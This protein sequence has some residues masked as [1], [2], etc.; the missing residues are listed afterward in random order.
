MYNKLSK[1]KFDDMPLISVLMAVRN[2]E[3]TVQRAIKSILDQSYPKFEYIIVDDGSNDKTWGILSTLNDPRILLLRN[4]ESR[5]LAYCLNLAFSFSRGD[6]IARMDADDQ[7][8]INRF[9]RQI[10]FMIAQPTIDILG[11]SAIIRDENGK[12]IGIRRVLTSDKKLKDDIFITQPFIHPSVMMKK[13]VLQ[14]LGGYDARLLR[15]Q[16]WDLWL[17]AKN[18]FYFANIGE[19]LL[20]YTERIHRSTFKNLYL[21]RRSSLK[22]LRR[23]IRQHDESLLLY[24][25]WLKQTLKSFVAWLIDR[26]EVKKLKNIQK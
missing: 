3:S 18:R 21:V 22:A 4:P 25:Y 23:Y 8:F 24:A 14:I 1:T 12:E 11:S 5:G 7:S 10:N 17:R 6:Y 15:A 26:T 2:G 13:N 9:E 20:F 19:P 16:D